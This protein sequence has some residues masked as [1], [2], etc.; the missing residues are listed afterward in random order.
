MNQNKTDDLVEEVCKLNSL[1]ENEL[2]KKLGYHALGLEDRAKELDLF[3]HNS[4]TNNELITSGKAYFEKYKQ[5]LKENICN[6]GEYCKKKREYGDDFQSLMSALI[7]IVVAGINLPVSLVTVLCVLAF[8]YG[9]N[10][11]CGCRD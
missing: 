3:D 5:Q 6:Q 2:Y 11:L 8:K 9:F 4:I 7:P 1:G 10:K